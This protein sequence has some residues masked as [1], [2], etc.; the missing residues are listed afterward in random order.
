MRYRLMRLAVLA[1]RAARRCVGAAT[2]AMGVAWWSCYGIVYTSFG[3][4][5]AGSALVVTTLF[6]GICWLVSGE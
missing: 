6:A 1:R 5:F 3:V 2:A 4:F